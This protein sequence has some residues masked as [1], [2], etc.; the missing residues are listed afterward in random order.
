MSA[1]SVSPT[2]SR[3]LAA[4]RD[5]AHRIGASRAVLAGVW[6]ASLFAVV[7]HDPGRFS[8]LMTGVAILLASY[9]LID[10]FAS[11][12]SARFDSATRR[13]LLINAGVSTA[14]VVGLAVTA[15]GSDAGST[16]AAFGVWAIASGA[17]QFG[18]AAYRRRAQ[19]GQIPMLISGGVSVIVGVMFIASSSDGVTHISNL[20]GY[21]LLGAVLFVVWSVRDAART[22]KAR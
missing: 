10:V 16:L 9:P 7:G 8:D 21:M 12:A 4:P 2:G 11:L 13:V 3:I 1:P 19:G 17:I 6:A 18:V 5:P 14:A 15:F 22:R 20:A